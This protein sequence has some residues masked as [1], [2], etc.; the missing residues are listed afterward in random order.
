MKFFLILMFL[1]IIC[2]AQKT[3]ADLEAIK[4]VMSDQQNAWNDA[5]LE[6]FMDGYWKSDQLE[7]VG[8]KGVTYGWET[9]LANYKKKY[10]TPGAMGKLIFTVIRVE[11]LSNNSA[12]LIGKYQLIRSSDEPSGH[13][14]LLWRKINGKWVIV[15]DHTS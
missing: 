14:T 13:F 4:K 1:P 15:T 10:P 7:F 8:S 9:T 11:K 12:F 5:N 3:D 6:K 2:T